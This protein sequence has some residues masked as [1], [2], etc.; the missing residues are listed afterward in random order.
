MLAVA[1][2][3]WMALEAGTVT[4]WDVRGGTTRRKLTAASPVGA[5]AFDGDQLV[6]AQW[7]GL[8]TRWDLRSGAAHQVNPIS[9]DTVSAAAFAA[10]AQ[11]IL[12]AAVNGE[13]PPALAPAWF[14]RMDRDLDGK[15]AWNEF[16][17]PRGTFR[18]LDVDA[19]EVVTIDEV[20]AI[21]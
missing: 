6:V 18:R 1:S 15:L 4:L 13:A 20:G 2:G 12:L 9:K 7:N 21:Q 14:Q 17:G 8:T 11:A 16:T 5:V 3:D 19:D 10:D